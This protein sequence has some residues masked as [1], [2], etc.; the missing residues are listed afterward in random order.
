MS[1]SWVCLNCAAVWIFESGNEF[2]EM[3][4]RDVFASLTPPFMLISVMKFCGF[5]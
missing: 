4:R 1:S 2:S 3:F 5:E